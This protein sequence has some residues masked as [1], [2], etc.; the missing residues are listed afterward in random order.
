MGPTL[1]INIGGYCWFGFGLCTALLAESSLIISLE[2]LV[3]E[4]LII[5][6]SHGDDGMENLTCRNKH[7]SGAR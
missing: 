5:H 4:P 7:T 6:L 3:T 1:I 2:V